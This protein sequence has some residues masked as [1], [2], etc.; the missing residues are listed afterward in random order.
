MLLDTG[1]NELAR[2]ILY[3]SYH[4]IV[5]LKRS[6]VLVTGPPNQLQLL[7]HYVS[8][9]MYSLRMTEGLLGSASFRCH[10]LGIQL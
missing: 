8:L 9:A 3:G 2:P 4:E 6:G 5:F 10:K 1:F 7:D